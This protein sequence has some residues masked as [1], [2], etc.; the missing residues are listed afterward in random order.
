MTPQD[1]TLLLGAVGAFFA[2]LGGGA[3]WLLSYI[4]TKAAASALREEK[5]RT[6]LSARLEYELKSLERRLD[7]AEQLNR[8]AINRIY[9]LEYFIDKQP[10]LTAPTMSGWPPP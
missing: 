1:A 10:G 2:A 7:K 4:E 6:E 9:Q 8:L 3:K 5:A